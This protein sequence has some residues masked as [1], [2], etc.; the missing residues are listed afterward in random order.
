MFVV[1]F[2]VITLTFL[3]VRNA[4]GSPF[5]RERK[6]PPAIEKQIRASYNLDGT[7]WEQLTTYLGVRKNVQGQY[8]GLLQGD[9]RL[10]TKY[11]D[12]SVREILSNS[13]PISAT[14]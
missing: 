11:R 9:L 8:S 4:P 14:L 7:L 1:L 6:I 2:C 13:L 10:S 5:S 12:R 3:L